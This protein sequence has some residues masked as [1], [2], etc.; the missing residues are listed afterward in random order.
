M[1][2]GWILEVKHTNER[3]DNVD[4]HMLS[5]KTGLLSKYCI[6]FHRQ[7]DYVSFESECPDSEDNQNKNSAISEICAKKTVMEL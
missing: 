1:S 2:K 4:I 5:A 7:V 6:S 3:S